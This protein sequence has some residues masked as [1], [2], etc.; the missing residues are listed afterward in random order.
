VTAVRRAP[1]AYDG[2]DEVHITTTA[3]RVLREYE[4]GEGW[5]FG[6]R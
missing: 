6:P 4:T 2:P 3:R 5:D 1:T